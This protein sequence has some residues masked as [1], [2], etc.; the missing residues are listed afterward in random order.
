MTPPIFPVG[1][2]DPGRLFI[3]PAPSAAR[4]H[5]D[6]RHYRSQ[7]VG[8]IVSL[9]EPAESGA[10]GLGD[11]AATCAE[12]GLEFLAFP[13]PDF[14]VPERAAVTALVEA[15]VARL[16]DGAGVAVHCRAGIGRSGLVVSC[17]L[18][19]FGASAV[20]AMDR[21]TRARGASVPE[22]AAQRAFVMDFASRAGAAR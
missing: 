2:A 19:A 20:E 17:T 14:G 22:T 10:L 16:R 7:A 4:L 1:G 5:D 13:I 3:M 9:L 21:V 18:A 8:T 11:E 12:Q 6:V 15:M